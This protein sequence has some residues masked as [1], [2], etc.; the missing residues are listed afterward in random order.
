MGRA[1]F[2][3]VAASRYHRMFA[4]SVEG[5]VWVE[6]TIGSMQKQ[7]TQR[8]QMNFMVSPS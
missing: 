6:D 8:R 5:V 2:Q 3:V 1:S 7:M 4:A